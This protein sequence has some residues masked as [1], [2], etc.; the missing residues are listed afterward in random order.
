[1]TSLLQTLAV[2]AVTFRSNRIE[3]VHEIGFDVSADDAFEICKDYAAFIRVMLGGQGKDP[4][5][6]WIVGGP[7][8]VGAQLRY[9]LLRDGQENVIV[10]RIVELSRDASTGVCTLAWEQLSATPKLPLRNYGCRWV[11]TPE[12]SSPDLPRCRLKW[13]RHFDE[14]MLLG[15]VSLA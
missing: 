12:P 6:E 2:E 3:V 15:V 9:R 4:A 10:E 8:Q 11:L 14:P 5:P 13:T 1:M 7:G